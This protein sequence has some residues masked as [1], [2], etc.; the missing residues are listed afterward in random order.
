VSTDG[1]SDY[2]NRTFPRVY[3]KLS[4]DKVNTHGIVLTWEGSDTQL[5]PTLLTGH[6]D[7]VP[8]DPS[9][10]DKW[11]YPPWEGHYDGEYLWGRGS[12]DDKH[13]VSAIL[14]AVTLLIEK[15]FTPRRTLILAFGFDEESKGRNGAGHIQTY[16]KDKY[17]NDGIAVLVDEGGLGIGDIFGMNAASPAVGEKGYVDV[18]FTLTTPGGHSSIP[19]DHTSIGIISQLVT[20]LEANPF[21]PLLPFESPV[22]SLLSCAAEHGQLPSSLKRDIKHGASSDKKGDK[23]RESAAKEVVKLGR[24]PRYLV[25]TSQAVDIIRAGVKVNALPESVELTANYRVAIG[26]EIQV[27]SFLSPSPLLLCAYTAASHRM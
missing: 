6:V 21:K 10:L 9:T 8:V 11:T 14:E 16:L 19:P 7:V 5:K 15:D 26:S 13:A 12:V 3:E 20:S 1:V 25:S 17:G 2:L 4:L 22:F 18:K 24:G 27:S 23:A